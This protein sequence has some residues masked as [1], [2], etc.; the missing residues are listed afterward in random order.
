MAEAEHEPR[1]AA[2]A[3]P[4]DGFLV[5]PEN[6]LAHAAASALARGEVEGLSPLVVHG[7]SGVGKSRLLSGLVAERLLRRP[8]SA[9][10]HVDGPGFIAA[11]EEAGE[12]ER[13]G[14]ADLRARLRNLD[15][16]V[17]D[18]VAA[19]EKSRRAMDELSH[20]LDALDAKG[21]A[22]AVGA[23]AGPGQWDG[24][25]PRLLGRLSA[26]LSVR[27]DPPGPATLRRYL[28]EQARA[29][30]LA[31]TLD[32]E[33]LDK[34]AESA[35]GFRTLDGWLARL[36]LEAKVSR[37]PIT[38]E[39]LGEAVEAD[40]PPAP[41]LEQIARAVADRFG[42]SLRDLRGHTRRATVVEPRH[43]AMYLA[44]RRTTLSFRSIG[45]YFGKRDPATVRHACRAA[46]GRIA[47]DPA[48][49]NESWLMGEG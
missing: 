16:L 28:L 6:G 29:R 15:L 7:P 40:L 23:K 33:A 3:H 43:L 10:A 26:G 41:T 17:I 11:V 2:R 9:I 49:G 35:D 20:T 47:E 42:V 25:P 24:W 31:P 30:E 36:G 48:L 32:P 5:G 1:P 39:R 18:D 44:R 46:E 21:A 34:L 19:L 14:W 22:V 27:I 13:G 4:W 12:A 8:D 38:A 37:R 45:V